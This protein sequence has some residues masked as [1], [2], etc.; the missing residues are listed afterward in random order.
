MTKH[1]IR[2]MAILISGIW[3]TIDSYLWTKS[4]VDSSTRNGVEIAAI[5]AAVQGVVTFYTV[6]AFKIYSENKT[7]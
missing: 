2:S 5:V 3:M 7:P 4:F 6:W 1:R